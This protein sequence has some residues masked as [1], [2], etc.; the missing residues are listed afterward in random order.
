[1]NGKNHGQSERKTLINSHVN[2]KNSKQQ[3]WNRELIKQII[4][5]LEKNDH[6]SLALIARNIGIPP[7]LRHCVWPILLKYHPMCVSPSIM[8]NTL[9]YDQADE[10]WIYNP[11]SRSIDEIESLIFKD[12]NKY[13]FKRTESIYDSFPEIQKSVKILKACIIGFLNKWNKIF[14][15]ESGLTWIAIG[16]AEWC[17]LDIKDKDIHVFHGKR[18][19]IS[20]QKLYKDY[21][22]PQ[23]LKNK[24][25]VCQFTFNEIYERLVLVILHSP[26]IVTTKTEMKGTYYPVLSGGD[27]LFQS[28]IFFKA[29]SATLPEL[30][31]PLT[32]EETIH[33]TK[34]SNWIYWWLKCS[35]SRVMHKQDRGYIW[36]ILLGWRPRP[37]SINFYLNYNTKIYHHL[38]NT[39]CQL[40]E[41]FF[42]KICRYGHDKFWFP[43]LDNIPLG[44]LNFKTDAQV[45]HELILRNKYEKKHEINSNSDKDDHYLDNDNKNMIPFSLVDPH[46][47]LLFIYIAILQQHEFK[48]LEFEEAEISEFLSNVP[49][50]SS[51]DDYNYRK[52]FED[53]SLNVNSV[54][55][56]TD[57]SI[58]PSLRPT[59][60]PHMMIEIGNDD[61]TSKSFEDIYQLA[62]DIWRKWIWKEIE[63]NFESV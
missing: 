13:F 24:L 21:P 62:G 30:Y 12:L 42:Q 57:E 52:A 28:R 39:Q 14:K 2:S 33:P 17:P 58:I 41:D 25:P 11:E 34:K 10:N 46:I 7:H 29:F 1:M 32:D 6:D 15:Y 36:D 22:L 51:I 49:L 56:D 53:V 31:Q 27:L 9:I 23:D 45:F 44:T 37:N 35:G 3:Q 43:D 26:G 20:I 40:S 60:S 5:L 4:E 47:Q 54:C 19:H 50:L 8:S 48:L 18:H 59:T 63:E 55:P 61:K 38:Y 16:L